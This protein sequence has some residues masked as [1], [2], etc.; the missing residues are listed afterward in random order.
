MGRRQINRCKCRTSFRYADEEAP[1]LALRQG[2]NIMAG[3][4]ALFERW[5]ASV[6]RIVARLTDRAN[7]LGVARSFS[8][9][10]FLYK[11]TCAIIERGRDG[12]YRSY[13]LRNLVSFLAI[14][15]WNGRSK[16]QVVRARGS[17]RER[18]IRGRYSTLGDAPARA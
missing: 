5:L 1:T 11:S 14:D 6:K 8:F 9:F 2:G 3:R 4:W 13:F 7:L 10:C 12:D 15:P 16:S 17:P 18:N